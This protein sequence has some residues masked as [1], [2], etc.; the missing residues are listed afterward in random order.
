[1]TTRVS[2]AKLQTDLAA[3]IDGVS[4]GSG[5]V[6]VER[7]GKP[8]AVLVDYEEYERYHKYVMERFR[9]A[10]EEF[11]ELNKDIDPEEGYREITALVEEV[12]QEHYERSRRHDPGDA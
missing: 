7:D 5:P 11:R 3:L 8:L 6:V 1:M 9:H 10:V 2:E 12:R 4:C